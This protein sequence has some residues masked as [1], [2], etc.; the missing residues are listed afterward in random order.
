MP[1]L[2]GENGRS[3]VL[4]L[5]TTGGGHETLLL[6]IPAQPKESS[7]EDHAGQQCPFGLVISQGVLPV[8]DSPAVP[9]TVWQERSAPFIEHNRALPPLP[10][11]GPPLGSRAPPSHLG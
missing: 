8:L 11:L 7:S 2:S 1:V 5:C 4:T 3:V 9:V 6:N 10:A